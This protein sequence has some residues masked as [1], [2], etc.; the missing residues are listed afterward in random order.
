MQYDILS[1]YRKT[2][3]EKLGEIQSNLPQLLAFTDINFLVLI[4]VYA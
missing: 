3:V 2:L 4:N 1:R